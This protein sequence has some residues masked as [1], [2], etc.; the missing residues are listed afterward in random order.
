MD[1]ALPIS[2]IRED[3][4]MYSGLCVTKGLVELRKKGVFGAALIK[5]RIYWPANIKGDAIDAHFASEEVENVDAAKKQEDGVAYHVFCMKYP[6]Y[7]MNIMTKYGTL[8]PIDKRTRRKFKCGGVT[9]TK[10]FM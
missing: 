10:E 9:G 6:D 4:M 3:V 8:E 2:S 7:V 5:K 1:D